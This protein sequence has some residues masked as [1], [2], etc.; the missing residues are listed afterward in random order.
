MGD[1]DGSLRRVHHLPSYDLSGTSRDVTIFNFCYEHQV[2]FIRC[3][4]CPL[5]AHGIVDEHRNLFGLTDRFMMALSWCVTHA[6]SIFRLVRFALQCGQGNSSFTVP[7]FL[8]T[9]ASQKMTSLV[10]SG[11]TKTSDHTVIVD[12]ALG[13]PSVWSVSYIQPHSSSTSFQDS[14]CFTLEGIHIPQ[15]CYSCRR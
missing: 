12:F 11:Q 3:F 4:L 5:T 9:A 8:F 15:A 2:I 6:R 7:S 10:H 13:L 14:L 1:A